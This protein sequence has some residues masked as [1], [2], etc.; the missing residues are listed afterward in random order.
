MQLS[1]FLPIH[2]NA[3]LEVYLS[4]QEV[5]NKKQELLD[6]GGGTEIMGM[7]KTRVRVILPG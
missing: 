4:T 2:L 5:A 3:V 7:V 1:G 6:I